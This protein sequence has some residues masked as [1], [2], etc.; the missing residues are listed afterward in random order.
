M[1]KEFPPLKSQHE[2]DMEVRRMRIR[3]AVAAGAIFAAAV[4][5]FA[6]LAVVWA[7]TGP[8]CPGDPEWLGW[9]AQVIE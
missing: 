6:G 1:R 9:C 4:T 3:E 2:I 7:E 5:M 8:G